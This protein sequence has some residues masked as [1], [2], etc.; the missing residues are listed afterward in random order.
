MDALGY[1]GA[2]VAAVAGGAINALG[3]G[4]TLVTFP[5][6]LGLGVPSVAA[7]M[8]NTVALSVGHVGGTWAQ[9]D[10]LH[11]QRHRLTRL[12]AAG[13]VGGLAG[14]LL[15]NRTSDERLRQIIP[16]LLG[17][18]TLLLAL[19]PTLRRR[20]GRHAAGEGRLDAVWLVPAVAG[21][22]V[23]GGYFGAGLGVMLLAVLGLGVHEPL[24]RANVLKQLLALAIN[25]VAAV[26]FVFTGE[27]WW[28][29]AGL[30]AVGSLV[31]G[32]FGGLLAGRL[33]PDR[34]RVVVVA[35]GA[36]I[37]VVY[38]LRVW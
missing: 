32:V 9:R 19:Q 16:V 13:A 35:V 11:G 10:G 2:T 21:A 37:T 27:V 6:L 1:V 33:D 5:A 31:G 26:F 14:A 3:G 34:F 17:A 15:L 23:Y 18:A 24:N 22:A 7:N 30:M 28:G 38:A 29:L 20:L 36:V 25:L 4:G 12:L 8:T